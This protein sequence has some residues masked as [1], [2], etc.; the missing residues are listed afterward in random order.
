LNISRPLN[1]NSSAKLHAK[2]DSNMSPQVRSC[3]A[4]I[5]RPIFI[6]SFV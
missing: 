4:P 6:P 2:K 1:S 5:M 3:A